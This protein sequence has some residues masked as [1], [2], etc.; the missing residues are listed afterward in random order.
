MAESKGIIIETGLIDN[1]SV[2][3]DYEM[4]CTVLRNLVS[5]SIK[6]S[7]P[8][9]IIKIS[10]K[11]EE[12]KII[13]SVEDSGIGMDDAAVS[14]L[15][16]AGTTTSRLGTSNETGT[17]LGLLI[18]QEFVELNG[19]KIWVESKINKGTKFHFSLPVGNEIHS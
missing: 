10:S 5:N 9:G 18:C 16:N 19:G 2:Y 4:I 17:G 14:K 12:E 1:I 8:R 6:F 11:A 13:I 15:F 3:A 7:K